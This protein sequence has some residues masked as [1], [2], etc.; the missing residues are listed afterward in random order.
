MGR[1]VLLGGN[2]SEY[3]IPVMEPVSLRTRHEIHQTNPRAGMS[4]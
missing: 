4:Q 3:Q 2:K 1:L